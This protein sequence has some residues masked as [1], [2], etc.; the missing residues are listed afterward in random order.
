M[1]V[2][3][4]MRRAA[5]QSVSPWRTRYSSVMDPPRARVAQSFDT[6][7]AEA[8]LQA[9]GERAQHL[10]GARVD[11]E[12]RPTIPARLAAVDDHDRHPS[13]G[14]LIQQA[15]ARVDHEGGSGDEERVGAG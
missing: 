12:A 15:D 2:R 13:L 3:P 9:L 11:L 10:R 7:E 1:S 6:T 8:R 4:W 14:R 5:F